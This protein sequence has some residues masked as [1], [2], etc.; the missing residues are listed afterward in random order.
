VLFHGY[1]G[2]CLK[3]NSCTSFTVGAALSDIGPL[4]KTAKIVGVDPRAYLLRAAYTAIAKPGAVT[5]PEDLLTA[6][7]TA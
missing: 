1:R 3:N 4:C 5:Y 6:G 7:P 2:R